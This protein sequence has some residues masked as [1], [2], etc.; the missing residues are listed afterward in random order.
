MV[1]LFL[2]CIVFS[3][4]QR[5]QPSSTRTVHSWLRAREMTAPKRRICP[6]SNPISIIPAPRP[7]PELTPPVHLPPIGRF[8]SAAPPGDGPAAEGG[9]LDSARQRSCG[10]RPPGLCA[11]GCGRADSTQ[12]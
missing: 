5:P 2:E 8:D 4:R 11:S 3:A 6:V 7:A 1:R 10:L 12:H 9:R